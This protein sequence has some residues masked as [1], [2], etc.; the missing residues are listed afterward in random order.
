MQEG[1]LPNPSYIHSIL[2]LY[3]CRAA[4]AA[5]DA[6]RCKTGLCTLRLHL[7][8]Q[9]DKNAAAGSTNRMAERNRAAVRVKLLNH[10]DAKILAN[11][12]GLRRKCLVCLDNVEIRNL[13]S[14]L[15]ENLLRGGN[16]TNPHNFRTKARRQ[17]KLPS[18]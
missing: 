11:R 9:C 7:V 8:K 6:K 14:G 5:A 17:Q 13:H 12:N 3:D 18:A 2:N 15:F 16:R 10:I 4:H 1:S